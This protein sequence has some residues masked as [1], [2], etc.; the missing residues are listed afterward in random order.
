MKKWNTPSADSP[1]RP[2]LLTPEAIQK[3]SQ[4][5]DQIK[6]KNITSAYGASFLQ[7]QGR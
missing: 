2:G 7:K 4:F 1:V 3:Q 6:Q 5:N